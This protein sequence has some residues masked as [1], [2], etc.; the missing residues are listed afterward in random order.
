GISWAENL[1]QIEDGECL[2]LVANEFLDALPI[3]QFVKSPRGWHERMIGAQGDSLCFALA[4]EAVSDSFVTKTLSDAPDGSVLEIAPAAR[5]IARETAE[6]IAR[7]GGV[8][9]FIDYGH[10]KSS[11]GETLQ[12]MRAH[13]YSDPLAEPGLAD[14][15]AHVD[16]AAFAEAAM[17]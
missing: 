10:T 15:T 1:P 5:A 14:I 9:L 13:A 17:G 8:A 16:F 2:L 3:R 12:A 11:I 6:R 7:C 4:P